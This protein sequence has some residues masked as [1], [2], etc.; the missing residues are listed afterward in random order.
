[1]L[2]GAATFDKLDG[3]LARRLGLT[4]PME[5]APVKKKNQHG[6]YLGRSCRCHQLLHRTGLES[7]TSP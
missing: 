1:M 3:A 2:V 5:D 6:E 7:F 4:E